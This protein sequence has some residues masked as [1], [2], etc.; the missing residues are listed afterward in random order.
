MTDSFTVASGRTAHPN[1]DVRDRIVAVAE[2]LFRDIGYQKTTVADI[3]RELRMSP[4]N[5]YRF[6][7]SKKAINEAV[8]SRLIGE[9]EAAIVAIAEGPGP[10]AQRLRACLQTVHLMCAARFVGDYKIHEMVNVAMTESWEVVEAHVNT[11][12]TLVGRLIAE[13]VVEGEF[14]V[15]DVEIASHCVML[16]WIR[17]FH[18]ELIAQC[19]DK[20]LPTLDQMSDFVLAALGH[21]TPSAPH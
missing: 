19:C 17:F 7:E 13:G 21:R 15:P 18:P 6:F 11:I 10:A 3:A 12:R 4:A 16:A 20:E 14:R 2:R 8:A 5:V 1:P 9:V